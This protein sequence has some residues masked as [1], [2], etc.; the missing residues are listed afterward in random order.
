[1]DW[2]RPYASPT[3]TVAVEVA[4]PLARSPTMLDGLFRQALTAA[5]SGVADATRS[6]GPVR[7]SALAPVVIPRKRTVLHLA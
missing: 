5:M 3:G 7:C 1:M 6:R 2:H 4:T